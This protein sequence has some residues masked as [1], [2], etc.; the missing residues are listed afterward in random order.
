MTES[1]IPAAVRMLLLER[2]HSYEQLESLLYLHGRRGEP[3]PAEVVA[4]ALRIAADATVQALEELVAN[5]LVVA[6]RASGTVFRYSAATAALDASVA[7]LARAYADQ[8][9]G[10][11]KLMSAYAI[12]RLRTGAI[13][14][15][16]DSF[17][18]GRKK[19]G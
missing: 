1:E 15:F 7:E 3:C 18:I 9:L 8:R 16:S 6:H 2:I 4:A 17:L 13:R 10:V 12:E 14:A 11:M 5:E 19:D